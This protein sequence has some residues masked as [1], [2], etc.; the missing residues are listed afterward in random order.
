MPLNETTLFSATPWTSPALVLIIGLSC[1]ERQQSALSSAR[2]WCLVPRF[3]ALPRPPFQEAEFHE[4]SRHNPHRSVRARLRIRLIRWMSGVE[5]CVRIGMQ[6]TRLG[7]PSVQQWGKSLPPHLCS[8][9]APDENTPPQPV[10]TSLKDAQL[11]RV[12]GHSMVLVIA[13][14]NSPKPCTDRGRTIMLPAL[15]LTLDGFQL[16]DHPLLRRDPFVSSWIGCG[17]AA[18]RKQICV[19]MRGKRT[20][21]QARS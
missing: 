20:S 6:Y 2:A 14:H 21:R 10:N 19:W 15:K 12:G 5:A 11:S 1:D 8:L 4:L 18:E 7:N 17:H 3:A 9:T 13:Q 16:R